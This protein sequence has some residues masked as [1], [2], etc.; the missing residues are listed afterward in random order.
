MKQK[1]RWS[2]GYSHSVDFLADENNFSLRGWEAL[3]DFQTTGKRYHDGKTYTNKM[4]LREAELHLF[5]RDKWLAPQDIS[6]IETESWGVLPVPIARRI[7]V[8]GEIIEDTP[9]AIDDYYTRLWPE[10]DRLV[11]KRLFEMIGNAQRAFDAFDDLISNV[12][13][14]LPNE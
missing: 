7:V 11:G 8:W 1:F 4:C 9:K 5:V 10:Y 6:K 14:M 13:R 2:D 3:R 12:E